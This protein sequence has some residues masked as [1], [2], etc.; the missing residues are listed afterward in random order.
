MHAFILL[1]KFIHLILCV[2]IIVGVLFMNQKSGGLSGIMGG[3]S[4]SMRGVKG[5]DEGM[6]KFITYVGI[7]LFASAI[8]LG[9]LGA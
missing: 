9:V 5:M 6:R 7:A 1:L 2:V 8:I 3:M 4:Q